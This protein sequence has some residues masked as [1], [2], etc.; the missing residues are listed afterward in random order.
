[1]SD[2][3]DL[4][5]RCL[6]RD[7]EA[8]R[9]LIERFQ[10]E[11]YGLSVRMLG[12]RHDA[13][14][15]SQEVFLRV[16]RSLHKWD[17]LRPLRPWIMGITVNRCRT[18]LTQRAKRPELSEFLQDTAECR[19]QDDFGELTREISAAV[20]EL[21]SD[22]QAAFLMFHDQGLPYEEIAEAMGHP[23]G[24]IK[25]WLHR[26]RTAMLMRLRERG[27]VPDDMAEPELETKPKPRR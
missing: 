3:P 8:V 27:M 12:N 24:T 4:V 26:A 18:W 7:P 25:T 21:R 10:S 5:R 14:D 22:Y 2:D 9:C 6:K 13:E 23:V 17:R 16:F 1:V 19:P 20:N 11:V 15:V